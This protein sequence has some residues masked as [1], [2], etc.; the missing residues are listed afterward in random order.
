MK[1][2]ITKLF[3]FSG[4]KRAEIAETTMGDIV[5]VAGVEGITIGEPS[6]ALKIP[7]RCRSSS[8]RAHHRH[9]VQRQQLALRRREASTSPAQSPRAPRKRA[10]HQRLDPR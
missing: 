1:T 3:T 9:P 8:S 6:P 5:A 2:R 7:S 10:A 4:L